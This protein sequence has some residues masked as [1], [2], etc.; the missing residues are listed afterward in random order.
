MI[1]GIIFT[2]LMLG[3]FGKLA[4]FAIKASWAI[5]KIIG[6]LIVLPIALI[7]LACV[8]LVKFAIPIAVIVGVVAL[9]KKFSS[10]NAATEAAE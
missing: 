5:I 3:I 4:V 6:C 8:G 10:D 1:L 7:V 2:V 9:I